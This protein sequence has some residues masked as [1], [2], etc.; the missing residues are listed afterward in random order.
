M[1]D[2]EIEL[3]ISLHVTSLKWK[4]THSTWG[5]TNRLLYFK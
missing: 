5:S 1:V 2:V 4:E 3:V